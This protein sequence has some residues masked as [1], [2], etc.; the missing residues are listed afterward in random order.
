L[1]T[2]VKKTSLLAA[3]SCGIEIA[4]WLSLKP[5]HRATATKRMARGWPQERLLEGFVA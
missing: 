2:G 4:V 5:S 3:Q 1:V